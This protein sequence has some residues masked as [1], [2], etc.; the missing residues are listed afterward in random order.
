MEE[1]LRVVAGIILIEDKVLVAKRP[2]SKKM[3]G[4]LEFPGGK[5]KEQ[6][7][8]E[9]AL[10][11]ELKEE[12]GI[13]PLEFYLWKVLRHDYSDFEVKLYFF[14]VKTWRGKVEAKEGQEVKWQVISK[15][16]EEEFLPADRRLVRELK[17]TRVKL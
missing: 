6:E 7:S 16:E 2:F 15:L 4:F 11:R 10:K 9:E 13:E 1:V 3:G 5:L 12:L 14:I 8:V 17:E